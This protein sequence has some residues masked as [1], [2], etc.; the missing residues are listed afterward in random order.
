MSYSWVRVISYA[1]SLK[2][3]A[4]LAFLAMPDRCAPLSIPFLRAASTAS[5]YFDRSVTAAAARVALLLYTLVVR[6]RVERPACPERFLLW[7]KSEG[8]LPTK[9]F[10]VGL[11]L[12]AEGKLLFCEKLNCGLNRKTLL[13]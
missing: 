10:S 2:I 1:C 4:K 13:L 5:S 9:I 8:R 6:H 12:S 3:F 7:C 11:L